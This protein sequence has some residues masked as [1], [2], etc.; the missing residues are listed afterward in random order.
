M[1][2]YDPS[3][4][5]LSPLDAASDPAL[6]MLYGGS[7]PFA[8]L[9]A[10]QQAYASGL[11]DWIGGQQAL[12]GGYY[13]AAG[14]VNP[15]SNLGVVAQGISGTNDPAAQL[16]YLNQLQVNNGFTDAYGLPYDQ[17][18]TYTQNLTGSANTLA[19]TATVGYNTP[20]MLV[21]DM[22]GE[23]MYTGAGFGGLQSATPLAQ[24]LSLDKGND[25]AWSLYTAAP[26]TEDWSLAAQ[27]TPDTTGFGVFTDFALPVLGTVAGGPLGA[28]LGAAASGAINDRSLGDVALQSALAGGMSYLGSG[29]INGFENTGLIGGELGNMLPGPSVG[30]SPTSGLANAAGSAGGTV[31]DAAGDIITVIANPYGS[32]GGMTGALTGALGSV[33][34]T[35]PFV[36]GANNPNVIEVMAN[37]PTGMTAEQIAAATGVIG[38]G[39]ALS[40]AIGANN[41]DL[42]EVTANRP[43][44]PTAG[45]VAAGAGVV[46]GATAAAGSAGGADG[47]AGQGDG[48]DWLDWL[49]LGNYGLGILGSLFGGGGGNTLGLGQLLGNRGELN[50]VFSSQLPAPTTGPSAPRQMPAQDWNTYALRPEQS[51]FTNIPQGGA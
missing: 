43:T 19:G 39:G 23:V 8:G 30:A 17:N 16:G 31:A 40:G 45:E 6:Q 5:Y 46:G 44:G 3:T 32:L 48:L 2:Y 51:F 47:A 13:S 1:Y 4:Y 38:A 26:G 20:V 15:Y 49:Q 7:D 41:P 22:T 50:P 14:A 35:T 25:A 29:L 34:A 24:Q 10:E 11:S 18:A 9:T 37:R 42:I 27:D 12:D 33:A 21:N 36:G 28:A